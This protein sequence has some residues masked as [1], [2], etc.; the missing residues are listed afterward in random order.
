MSYFL[1][2]YRIDEHGR[3]ADTWRLQIIWNERSSTGATWPAIGGVRVSNN[4]LPAHLRAA[5]NLM[6]CE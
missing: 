6:W 2:I 3:L 1:K 4:V 5:T